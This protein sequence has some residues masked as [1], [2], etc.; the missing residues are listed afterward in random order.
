[1]DVH[2]SPLLALFV[3]TCRSAGARASAVDVEAAGIDLLRRWTEPHRSYHNLTHLDEVLSRLDEIEHADDGQLDPSVRL[4]AW[5][6]YAVYAGRPGRDEAESADLARR[7]LVALAVPRE[8]GDHTADLVLTTAGHDP[9]ADD[10]GAHALC[11][12]DLA[13]LAAGADRYAGYAA[14]VRSEYAHVPD[15][16]FRRG[17][18]AVLADLLSRAHLFRTQHGLL[19]WEASARVNLA[20]EIAEL[21]RWT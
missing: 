1:M 4:A 3:N 6:H 20:R 7:E 18:A 19:H 10:A 8:V 5:W 9:P 21:S 15:A 12:A 16:H 17:R 11:D 2:H 13:V 14:G